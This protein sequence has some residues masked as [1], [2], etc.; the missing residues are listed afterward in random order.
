MFIDSCDFSGFKFFICASKMPRDNTCFCCGDAEGVWECDNCHEI[1]LCDLC[2]KKYE[3]KNWKGYGCFCV[4]PAKIMCHI[5]PDYDD[6]DDVGWDYI[7]Y[8]N[9]SD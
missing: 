5:S 2:V 8:E 6:G 4:K 3:E 9:D 1:P 7:E